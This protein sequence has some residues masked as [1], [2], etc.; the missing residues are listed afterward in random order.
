MIEAM[1]SCARLIV[2]C[3]STALV[4]SSVGSA[5]KPLLASPRATA[6]PLETQL[7]MVALIRKKFVHVMNSTQRLMSI[8]GRYWLYSC[9]DSAALVL[10]YLFFT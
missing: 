3:A 2:H 6:L 4:S 8:R 9:D 10:T 5:Q 1:T 7:A